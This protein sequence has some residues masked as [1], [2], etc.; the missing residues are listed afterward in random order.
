MELG[1]ADM[2]QINVVKQEQVKRQ[3]FRPSAR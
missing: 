2:P 3:A 1:T